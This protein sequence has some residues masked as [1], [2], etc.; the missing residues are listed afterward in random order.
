MTTDIGRELAAIKKRVARIERASRLGSASLDDTA[1][2]V[3]DDAGSLRGLV[4]QQADGTTA[5]NIVN[6]GPPPA[7]STPTVAPALGGIAVTWDGTLAGGAVLPLD[8]ARVEVHASPVNGFT[9]TADTLQA[10]IETPQ[11][12]TVY[13]PATADQYV[14]LMARNTSGTASDPT[15]QAGPYAPRAVVDT[16]VADGSI[17]ETKIADDAVTTPKVKAGAIET[18]QLNALA[19]TTPK[20]AVGSVDAVALAADAITGKTITG[21]TVTG[22]TVQTGD[23]GRRLVLSPESPDPSDTADPGDTVPA[24]EIWSGAASEV[25]PGLV[26]GDQDTADIPYIGLYA[27]SALTD[28]FYGSPI[29][30]SLRMS[31]PLSGEGGTFGLGNNNALSGDPSLSGNV[32]L[33][34]GGGGSRTAISHIELYSEN[35]DQAPGGNLNLQGARSWVTLDGPIVQAR[36]SD[37]SKD[38]FV[39]LNTS[40]FMAGVPVVRSWPNGSGV[41]TAGTWQTPSFSTGWASGSTSGT[42]QGLQFRIDAEDNVHLVGV[43]HATAA[44]PN[45]QLFTLPAA[46]GSNP[47]YR[48]AIAQRLPLDTYVSSSSANTA[49]ASMVING[50]G[51]VNIYC[52]AA[53]ASNQNFAVNAKFPLGNIA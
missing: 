15:P 52:S 20:L 51:V 37:S 13:I 14:I 41:Q 45:S 49:N 17:T 16:D 40:L 9:P 6:G 29:T 33:S 30:A 43:F 36:A 12:A 44:A 27:P 8:W 35:G 22:S 50:T 11:G 1:L 5:V 19:V 21:G 47:T 4:G 32:H 7:P 42:Y 34:G 31:S 23:S 28:S 3:R 53:I 48:P 10:T 39:T 26:V 38:G 18:A 2:E 25:T 46:S 24:L